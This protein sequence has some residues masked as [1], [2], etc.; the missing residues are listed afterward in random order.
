MAKKILLCLDTDPQPSVFDSVVAVDAGVDVLLRHA[1]VT[2][3]AVRKLVHGLLFTRGGEDLHSSAVYIGGSDVT[4]GEH[5]LQATRE[6]FLGPTQVS[7]L[8]DSNGANT[9]A[10]A[11]V[12]CAGRHIPL[13]PETIALVLGATGS[14]GQRV[15][16]MLAHEGVDVRVASRRRTHAEAVCHRVTAALPGALLSPHSTT[17]SDLGDLLDGVGLVISTGAAGV[18]LLDSATRTAA[19]KLQVVIDVNAVP[20]AGLEGIAVTDKATQRGNQTCY[21]ALAVGSLKMKIHKAAIRQL[22]ETNN[23]VLDC[24]EIYALGKLLANAR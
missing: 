8:H 16:R 19:N 10:A 15:V 1:A 12:V 18:Q 24:D 17:D 21:G 9:T 14:V 4:M 23:R 2:P 13:G 11:A 7:V 6:S 20:P 5:L 3:D 22:F